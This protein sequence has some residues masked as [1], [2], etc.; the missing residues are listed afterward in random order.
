MTFVRDRLPLCISLLLFLLALPAAAASSRIMLPMSDG[1]RLDTR[2][3]TPLG[4]GPWPTILYRT[5]YDELDDDGLLSWRSRGYALVMQNTRGRYASEGEASL[6]GDDGWC[7][8]QDGL[9]T[10]IWMLAQS[11]C[12]GRIG[13]LGDSARGIT[14]NMLAGANPPGIYAQWVSHASANL[15]DG[16][17]YYGGQ[18]RQS[19]VLNWVQGSGYSE[20]ALLP[21][22]EH[23]SY[24]AFWEQYDVTTRQHLRDYPVVNQA[25]WYDTFLQSNIDNFVTIREFGGPVAREH[26][27]LVVQLDAHGSNSGAIP[28]PSIAQ[29]PPQGYTQTALMAR[30]L[31][32]DENGFEALPRVAYYM[33]GDLEDAQAPG[34]EWRYAEDWPV[35]ALE[36]RVY[37]HGDGALSLRLPPEDAA[38]LS[39]SYDPAD[40]VPTLGG[41]NLSLPRGNHDQRPVESRDDVL[42]FDSG[43]LPAPVEVTGRLWV[44]LYASS[45]RI[46]TDFSAKLTDVYPDGRS[47]LICDGIRRAAYRDSLAAPEFMTPGEVY[48][49]PI[50]LWST[51]ITFAA[52]HHIRIAVS[53]SNYPRFAAN[54]NTGEDYA[55]DGPSAVLVSENTVYADRDRPSHIVL[56]IT[57]PD[58]DGDGVFDLFDPDAA[59]PPEDPADV[60]R[61]GPVN[62]VDVQLVINGALGLANGMNSDLDGDGDTDAVDVQAVINAALGLA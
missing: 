37:F 33:M 36:R 3:V 20:A 44:N 32:D 18:F 48:A 6:F 24:D 49:I 45:D 39:F 61:D 43:P 54:P 21:F 22:V 17:V 60:D 11:W 12:N 58:S 46:D 16:S 41:A 29:N 55:L 51:A 7:L 14:Q 2:V 8:H 4:G 25:G 30:Y 15:Y 35:P 23:P 47:I 57:G 52:G 56:P 31:K 62:A 28:W 19:K 34:N 50:D 1:V 59:G 53:S 27:M 5:P 42:L 40:P 26:S 9:D 13:T 10:V 38:P